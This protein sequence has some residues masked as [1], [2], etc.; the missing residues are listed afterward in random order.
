MQR[1]LHQVL[2]VDN[3]NVGT[4]ATDHH[5]MV[6]KIM[7]LSQVRIVVFQYITCFVCVHFH[8]MVMIVHNFVHL[9]FFYKGCIQLASHL[10]KVYI[11]LILTVLCCY[12]DSALYQGSD[13]HLE[14]Y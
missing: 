1:C 5:L 2:D 3:L 8:V 7:K 14:V 6:G 9:G 10:H 12:V 13:R 11:V 4:M